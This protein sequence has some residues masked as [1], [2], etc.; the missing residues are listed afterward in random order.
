MAAAPLVVTLRSVSVFALV[1]LKLASV[2]T[3]SFGT[4]T[5]NVVVLPM[6]DAASSVSVPVVRVT[7]VAAALSLMVPAVANRK[8]F[9]RLLT[10]APTPSTFMALTSVLSPIVMVPVEVTK[11]SSASETAKAPALAP[12]PMVVAVLGFSVTFPAPLAT[13]VPDRVRSDPV[14]E[15][16]PPEE[17]KFPLI[18]TKP[19]WSMVKLPPAPPA[20]LMVPPAAL[21]KVVPVL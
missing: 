9:V 21:V 4:T 19:V 16:F 15:M 2:F 6:V 11:A 1:M 13:G 20:V 3:T 10:S 5:S 7:A 8:F 18:V 14:M 17:L 12:T